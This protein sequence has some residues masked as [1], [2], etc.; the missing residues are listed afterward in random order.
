MLY[1]INAPFF[2][3]TVSATIASSIFIGAAIYNGDLKFLTKGIITILSYAGFLLLIT[4]ARIG[5]I[6]IN[7]LSDIQKAMAYAGINTIILLTFFY[8][9]GM[10][11]GVLAVYYIHRR[12]NTLHLGF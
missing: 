4:T 10:I 5:N 7:S 12:R 8:L 9:V 1:V 3:E 6:E 2:W 11:I